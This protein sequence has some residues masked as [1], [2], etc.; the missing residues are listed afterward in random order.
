MF[1]Y[2]Y[3]AG[4]RLTNR[5]TP[6]KGSTRYVY[7]KIG[8]LTLVD[9]P[10][11]TDISMAYDGNNRLTSMTD[12]S[13]SSAFAYAAFGALATEDGPWSDDTIT[14]SYANGRRSGFS[15]QQLNS[16]AWP[17]SYGYDAAGRLQSVAS[18]AGAFVYTYDSGLHSGLNSAS[19]LVKNIAL[20]NGAAITNTYDVDLARL[21]STKLVN[22][23][24]SVL[25]AH[26][27]DYNEL[28]QRYRQTRTDDSFVEYAYDDFGQL[29]SALG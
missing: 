13:G 10:S 11:S 25:N 20:P 9:Y 23:S 7:D 14:Y 26:T 22:S 18:P 3:D 19:A 5:G 15:L 28:N 16:S 24:R 1:R 21:G 6:A 4:G 2:A 29:T 27:Y 8:N 12:A 17:V